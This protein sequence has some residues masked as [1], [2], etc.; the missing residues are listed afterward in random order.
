MN[1]RQRLYDNYVS[2]NKQFQ[3]DLNPNPYKQDDRNIINLQYAM[4]NWLK[5]IPRNGKVLDVACGS[6][7]ILSLLQIE[8]FTD[9]YGVDISPEQVNIARQQFSQVI[10]ADA[11]EYLFQNPN[12]FSLITGFDIL[13][14]FNKDEAVKFLDAIYS[15][16]VPGGRLIL[17]L[18]NG[19]SPL[20]GGVVYGDLTHEV[21]YTSVSLKHILLACSFGHVQFQEHGPQP[22]SLKGV[23]R[24]GIWGVIRQ[25]IKLIHFVETGGIS[26]GI[27]TRVMRAYAV[28]A[29]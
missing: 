13:E 2:A 24:F 27:Y 4:S 5:E 6:G 22:T 14:H 21:T 1:Y 23:V 20:S 12:K 16:L 9:L 15:A 25:I 7:N 19:D 26:T 8:G 10:C 11:I 3:R 17:Q 18:P 28:K 29:N